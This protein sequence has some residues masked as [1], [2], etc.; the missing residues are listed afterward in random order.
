MV[1]RLKNC[2]DSKALLT[3][4]M[5]TTMPILLN[6]KEIGGL[7]R[8]ADKPLEEIPGVT[9]I[10]GSVR[11]PDGV[12]LRTIIT[13]P[14]GEKA[15]KFPLLF[16]QWVSCG[17]VEYREGSSAHELLAQ[18]ARDSGLSLVRVE[19]SSDGDS[20]GPPCSELDYDTE[21]AHYIFA[22][23]QLLKSENLNTDKVF[24]YGSSLGATTAPLVAKS[25]QEEGINI[26]GIMVQ[27][28]GAVT[29]Y[30]RMLAFE[31]NYLERR[32]VQVSP[33]DIHDQFLERAK[34]H[35]EY[36]TRKRHPNDIALDSTQMA[37]IREDILGLG[38]N[39]HYGRPFSWHQQAASHNFLS[40]WA[41]LNAQV[42][43]IFNEYD[44]FEARHG[45]WLIAD[46]VNRLRPGT[47][48]FVER[49]KIGHSDDAYPSLLDAYAFERGKPAWQDAADIMNNWLSKHR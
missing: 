40:A 44:Q 4:L 37:A 1:R 17:S 32:P 39:D 43:V 18:L 19:R 6:A 23:N 47:A 15:P 42:L 16:T 8:V 35:Y 21:L 11:T 20:I 14:K 2:I 49:S 28:G 9:S 5:I 41:K 30:E 33:S 12:K 38:E 29:Y 7:Q 31:R 13:R 36:L 10:Y 45:H 24:V 26:A 46:T 25:L 48:Q 22:F 3:A 27:G 34:F